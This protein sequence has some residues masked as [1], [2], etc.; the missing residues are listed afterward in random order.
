MK[1]SIYLLLLASVSF[2]AT[3]C[4]SYSLYSIDEDPSVKIDEGLLGI[5]KA[6]EDTNK[7]DYILIQRHYDLHGNFDD[8]HDKSSMSPEMYATRKK[9]FED[10]NKYEYYF[11]RMASNGINPLY[12]NWPVFISEVMGMRFLNIQYRNLVIENGRWQRD[13]DEEGYFF[14][15]LI[16]MNKSKDTLTTCIVADKSMKLLPNSE[17]VRERITK[18]LKNPKFY[19]D[20]LHFYKVSGFHA[21]LKESKKIANPK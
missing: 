19:S 11:T 14:V 1:N 7:K 17:T 13:K 10:K 5:W 12:E 8:T 6:V 18:N 2:L 21:D 9:G 3:G 20:T 4:K 15:R 16:R